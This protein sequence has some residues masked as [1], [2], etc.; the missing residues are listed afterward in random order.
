MYE[1]WNSLNKCRTGFV[2]P[3]ASTRLT[4]LSGFVSGTGKMYG[5]LRPYAVGRS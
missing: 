4:I 3:V 1:L 5:F 2:A